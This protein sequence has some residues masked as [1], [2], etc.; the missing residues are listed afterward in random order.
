MKVG[1]MQLTDPKLEG[2][3][4]KARPQRFCINPKQIVHETFENEVLAINLD[5]G[6]YYSLPGSS[7]GLWS[8]LAQ[9]AAVETMVR[10]L[11]EAYHCD[12]SSMCQAVYQF[13]ERLREEQLIVPDMSGS[14]PPELKPVAGATTSFVSFELNKFT[15]MQDLLL[16]DPIHDVEEAGWPLARPDAI[17]STG[18]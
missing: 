16:L 14:D 11:A 7:S 13:L 2:Q 6:T 10:M 12:S 8:L 5:T 15:D 1:N 17:E 18:S 3:A 9:G 4:A